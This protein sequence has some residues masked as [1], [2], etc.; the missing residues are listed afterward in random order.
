VRFG[1]IA[2]F[3][4]PGAAEIICRTVDWVEKNDHDYRVCQ[5]LPCVNVPSDKVVERE[6]LPKVSDIIVSMGGDGTLLATARLVGQ[7]SIPILGINLGS[8]GFLTQVTMAEVE[9]SLNVI[10][11]GKHKVEER[12]LLETV[13]IG[14]KGVPVSFAL[15]DVVVD[16]GDVARIIELELLVNDEYISTYRADGL[17]ISTPTGSTAYNAAVGGPILDPCMRAIVIAPMAPQSLAARPLLFGGDDKVL[18]K[19]SSSHESGLLTIDGQ[20]SI[21]LVNGDQVVIKRAQHSTKLITMPEHSFYEILRNKLN[22][23]VLPRSENN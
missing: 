5:K 17:I 21:P 18:V 13:V 6:E 15:N 3:R 22:W 12:M 23:G 4:R 20:V 9:Q 1:I 14:D 2:N 16:R 11:A 8:L 7:L 10:A 19:F